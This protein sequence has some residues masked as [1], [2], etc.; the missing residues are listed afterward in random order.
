MSNRATGNAR[1]VSLIYVNVELYRGFGRLGDGY[2]GSGS[3]EQYN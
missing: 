1:Y 3:P 2:R